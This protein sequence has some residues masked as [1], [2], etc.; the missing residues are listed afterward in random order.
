VPRARP[1]QRRARARGEINIGRPF[2]IASPNACCTYSSPRLLPKRPGQ[3]A[4]YSHFPY[5]P[6]HTNFPSLNKSYR[7]LDDVLSIVTIAS[8]YPPDSLCSPFSALG[9]ILIF[10]CSITSEH[11]RFTFRFSII[12]ERVRFLHIFGSSAPASERVQ[13][14]S[15]NKSF[16]LVEGSSGGKEKLGRRSIL[17]DNT[18]NQLTPSRFVIYKVNSAVR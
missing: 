14:L 9:S 13:A 6:L 18:F 3:Q 17:R 15:L 16:Q 2:T 11:V 1:L 8:R 7:R 5:S 10:R 4:H 12:T